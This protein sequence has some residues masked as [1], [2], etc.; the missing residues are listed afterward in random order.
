MRGSVRRLVL[1][2][3]ADE[4]RLGDITDIA[5]RTE[6]SIRFLSDMFHARMYRVAAARVGVPD[7]R[8]PVDGK[9]RTAGQLYELMVGRFNRGLRAAMP[10]PSRSASSGSVIS[11]VCAGRNT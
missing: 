3:V 5:E 1:F 6:T 4:I 2:D 7:Y 8:R 10:N 11:A 9:L